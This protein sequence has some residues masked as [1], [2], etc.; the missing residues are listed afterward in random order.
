MSPNPLPDDVIKLLDKFQQLR[1]E[2][3]LSVDDLVESIINELYTMDVLDNTY[4]L[5]TSDNGY[6]LGN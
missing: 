4:V 6:H 1:W 5:Y 2:S 3:L